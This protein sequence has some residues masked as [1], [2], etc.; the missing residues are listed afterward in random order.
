MIINFSQYGTS[1]GTRLQGE[2]FREDIYNCIINNEK[3]TIN[4][5]KVSIISGSFADETFG[6]LISVNN[7]SLETLKKYIEFKNTNS[8]INLILKQEISKYIKK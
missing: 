3:I 5:E 1:L 7:L 4:F 6:K 2:K 8:N